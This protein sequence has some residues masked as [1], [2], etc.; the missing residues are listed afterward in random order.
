M[1]V[2]VSLTNDD[3]LVDYVEPSSQRTDPPNPYGSRV[4][5]HPCEMTFVTS[6]TTTPM[7]PFSPAACPVADPALPPGNTLIQ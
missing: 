1:Y 4:Y 5:S 6:P 2:Y 7:G 3:G